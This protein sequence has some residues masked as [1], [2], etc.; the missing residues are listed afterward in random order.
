MWR[1]LSK[2]ATFAAAFLTLAACADS[3]TQS[4]QPL[5]QVPGTAPSMDDQVQGCV[6]EGLCILEPVTPAPCDPWPSLY[7]CE[8]DCMTSVLQ[9]LDQ[10]V[11][12]C[13]GGGGE[14]AP[15]GGGTPPPPPGDPGA[16]CPTADT[17][18]CQ[19]EPVCEVDCPADGEQ[20]EESDICPQ[21]VRGK[22]ATALVNVAGRNHEFKFTG[23]LN[24]VNRLVGRSPVWYEIPG[25]KA[26][27]DNW[28]IAESGNILL[29][30]WGR[31]TLGN[32]LW[33]GTVYVQDTDL[34]LVMSAGHPDF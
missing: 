15:G 12:S 11:Q 7:W 25:P 33:V 17:G 22:T 20:E 5:Q 24:R 10:G 19:T 2:L 18:A 21:P 27:N 28:W 16:L 6:L 14:G 1:F 13:P 23:T 30:C 26:S 29:V 8:P 9:P 32:S 3:P 34:H 31:W 4:G